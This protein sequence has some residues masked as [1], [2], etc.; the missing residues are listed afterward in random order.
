MVLGA[1]KNNMRTMDMIC[2]NDD[3]QR[4]CCPELEGTEGVWLVG[5]QRKMG[6]SKNLWVAL[7]FCE[8]HTN[9]NSYS[10]RCESRSSFE[11]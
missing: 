6:C 8:Q 10:W 3:L 2:M 4:L 1:N 9:T 5:K 7:Q 11:I